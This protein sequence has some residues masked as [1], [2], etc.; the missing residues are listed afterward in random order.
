MATMLEW[1]VSVPVSYLHAATAMLDGERLVDAAVAEAL[2]GPVTALGEALVA[3]S[4]PRELFL[5]H[6]QRCK[7]RDFG[8]CGVILVAA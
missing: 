8:A 1:Q 6:G 3:N 7:R 2:A 4:L 5:R